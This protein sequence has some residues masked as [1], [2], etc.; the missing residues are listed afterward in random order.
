MK[1]TFYTCE[2]WFSRRSLEIQASGYL[3]PEPQFLRCN[4]KN[5]QR[6][7]ILILLPKGGQNSRG[8]KEIRRLDFLLCL[9]KVTEP[10]GMKINFSLN[11]SLYPLF[12]LEF[13]L[14]KNREESRVSASFCTSKMRK[15]REKLLVKI[16][17]F[18]N[19]LFRENI[20]KI[21]IHT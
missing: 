1:L 3:L 16:L 17:Q 9:A 8:N 21:T 13:H 4:Y 18:V 19:T 15:P 10:I 20:L 14:P 6:F 7:E 2:S 11:N 12:L 5:R